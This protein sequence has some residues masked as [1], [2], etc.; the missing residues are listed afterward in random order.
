MVRLHERCQKQQA[1]FPQRTGSTFLGERRIRRAIPDLKS[2][3]RLIFHLSFSGRCN[4]RHSGCDSNGCLRHIVRHAS[5]QV[6]RQSTRN[7]YHDDCGA[8]HA[9]P[10]HLQRA[11]CQ[12]A[13]RRDDRRRNGQQQLHRYTLDKADGTKGS[14]LPV[15]SGQ[16]REQPVGRHC[17]AYRLLVQEVGR[18]L[19]PGVAL[20]GGDQIQRCHVRDKEYR[21]R[22]CI[23]AGRQGIYLQGEGQYEHGAV[24]AKPAGG[25]LRN[26]PLCSRQERQQDIH[27]GDEQPHQA[28]EIYPGGDG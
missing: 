4:W 13:C 2:Q 8:H 7:R 22:V 18:E 20:R 25:N 17:H 24:H 6:E 28:D 12:K 23:H 19:W 27:P 14:P 9:L 5:D 21:G 3:K 10:P 15:S 26:H 16:S 1:G 11:E